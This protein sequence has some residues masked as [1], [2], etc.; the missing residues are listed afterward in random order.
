MDFIRFAAFNKIGFV[1]IAAKQLFQ[2]FMTDAC[3]YCG[4][5]NFVSVEM[6]DGKDCTIMNG[7]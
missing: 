7:I 2:F 4:F 3:Q 1:T 5:G 6:E